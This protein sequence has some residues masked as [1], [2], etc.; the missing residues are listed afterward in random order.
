MAASFRD[1][2]LFIS[3]YEERSFTGA[4][5][6][7]GATQSGVSQHI[8][9]L[10]KILGVKLFTR[11]K[12]GQ[13]ITTPAADA[14]YQRCIE[15]LRAHDLAHQA[16]K[17]YD[18]GLEGEIS[19]GLMPAMTRCVLAPVL[20]DFTVRHPNVVVR[21]VEGYSGALTRQVLFGELD[22]A[23]VPAFPGGVGLKS[24][25]FARTPELFVKRKN[26]GELKSTSARLADLEP[27]RLAVPGRDNT[28]R[29]VLDTYFVSNSV[30]ID[31]L[32]ELDAMLGTL[33]FIS[34]SN[35]A[36]IL[37]AIMMSNADDFSVFDLFK[38]ADPPLTLD[39]ILIEASRRPISDTAAA[40][41]KLLEE[42]TNRFSESWPS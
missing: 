32:L 22:F 21:I 9:K 27:L 5:I 19:V 20:A 30:R 10:E 39:L 11:R 14:Y 1:I 7:E 29:R 26:P 40:F 13:V 2:E 12:K 8:G 38:I 6:R 4:A 33:A 35:W 23:I 24:R 41:L 25:L 37:P 31:R 34:Q 3:A 28:R 16:I 17:E 18:C 36:A 42:Q 15:V